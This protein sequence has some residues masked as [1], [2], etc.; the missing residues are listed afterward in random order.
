MGG[1]TIELCI[2]PDSSS[3]PIWA[4]MPWLP[5]VWCIFGGRAAVIVLGRLAVLGAAEGH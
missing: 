3:R 4:F 5:L 2:H 1:V